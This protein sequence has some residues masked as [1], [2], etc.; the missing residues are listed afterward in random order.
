MRI[1]TG[2]TLVLLVLTGSG[3]AL[4]KPSAS[5]DQQRLQI[6]AMAGDALNQAYARYPEARNAVRRAAGYGV[7]DTKGGKILYG[8][9][10]H[11]EGVVIDNATRKHTYMKMFELQPGLGFGFSDFRLVF[12]FKTKAALQDFVTSGWQF[13]TRMS[14][15][16]KNEDQGGAFDL[17]Y[18]IS[19]D[20]T[21][22]QMTEK[23]ALVGVSITGAKYWLNDELN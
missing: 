19:P 18:A 17:G 21:V 6:N 11:G 10:D 5:P 16:A 14:A 1:F 8:G 9:M 22:Y 7:F 2:L 15:A 13:S 23:G 3:C 12:I 4:F 20:I